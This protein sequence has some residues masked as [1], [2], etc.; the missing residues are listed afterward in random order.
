MAVGVEG[1][2]GSFVL[3]D[4]S[5]GSFREVRVVW[6]QMSRVA[7]SYMVLAH[8]GQTINYKASNE[9]L[10]NQTFLDIKGDTFYRFFSVNGKWYV[11]TESI[12]NQ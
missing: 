4:I 2:N 6:F 11:S 3:P 7:T 5:D 8:S 12:L 10:A 1:Y 9:Y